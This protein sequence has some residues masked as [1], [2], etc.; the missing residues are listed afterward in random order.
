M[1]TTFPL[2]KL[3]T[4]TTCPS[5][6]STLI[7]SVYPTKEENYNCGLSQCQ[8]CS[9]AFTNP[10]IKEI[11]LKDLYLRSDTGGIAFARHFVSKVLRAL[12]LSI[13]YRIKIHPELNQNQGVAPKILDYGC[14][15]GMLTDVMAKL[16]G[17]NC[18]GADYQVEMVEGTS[19]FIVFD[20]LETEEY[21][22]YFDVIILRHVLEHTVEPK[23]F[24]N[25]LSKILKP[26]GKIIIEVPNY[27]SHWRKSLA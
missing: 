14:G 27:N 18:V 6:L 5:C 26:H 7:E 16:S 4:M 12:K 24:L 8:T 3:E 23:I 20:E 19:R 25:K 21:I 10:R 15:D 1:K 2:D 17:G 9:L 11:Y 13:Y 22:N